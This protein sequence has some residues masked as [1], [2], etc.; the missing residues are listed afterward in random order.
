VA[1]LQTE[2]AKGG[3]YGSQRT[4]RR[5]LHRLGWVWKRTRVVLGRPDPAEHAKRGQWQRKPA[6]R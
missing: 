4:I 5:T 3:W 1:L 2:L 6:R